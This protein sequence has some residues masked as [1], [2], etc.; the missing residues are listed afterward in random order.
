MQDSNAWN[1]V[2]YLRSREIA[3]NDHETSRRHR[4]TNA[5]LGKTGTRRDAETGAAGARSVC[6]GSRRFEPDALLRH[7]PAPGARHAAYGRAVRRGDGRRGNGARRA[8]A[9]RWKPQA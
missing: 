6:R 3:E 7:V 8:R 1:I 9:A 2:T 4:L 5:H